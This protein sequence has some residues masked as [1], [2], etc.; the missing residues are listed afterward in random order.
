MKKLYLLLILALAIGGTGLAQTPSQPSKVQII[1]GPVVEYVTPNQAL[2]AW[3]TNTGGST[4][5]HY[6]TDRNNLSQTAQAPYANKPSTDKQG[7]KFLTHRVHIKN[8]QPGTTYYFTVDSGEG[9]GTGTEA[10]SSVAQFTTKQ[11][12]GKS[13]SEGGQSGAP[14]TLQIVNGPVVEETGNTWAVVAW[15]TNDGASSVVKYGTDSKNLGQMAQS[16]YVDNETMKPTT[17]R[18]RIQNLQPGTTYYF[19]VD[20]AQGDNTTGDAKSSVAQF[21]TKK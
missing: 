11:A 8:L 17:H 3:S 20:S 7:A 1:N 6:G 10:K 18:V 16:A 19:M 15:T 5:V 13:D 9:E 21:T 14:K 12:A 4:V 2:I